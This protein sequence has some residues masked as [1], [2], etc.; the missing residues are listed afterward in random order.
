VVIHPCLFLNEEKIEIAKQ[1]IARYEWARSIYHEL[2][3]DA[4]KLPQAEL[5]VFETAW[6]QEAKKKRWQEIYPEIAHH[7]YF[8][9]RTLPEIAWRSALVYR[10]G[11]R[12]I[13]AK[14][15][16]RVLLHFTTYSFEPVHPDVGMNW[17]SWG[18]RLLWTY[19]ALY[20]YC[21]PEERKKLDDFFARLVNGVA[22]CDDLWIRENPGGQ[23]NNHYAWHKMMMAAYGIFYGDDVWVKRAIESENGIRS[24]IEKGLLDDGIWFESSLNYHFAALWPLYMTAEMFRSAGNPFDLYTHRFANGRKLED[25][26]R[27]IIEIAFPDLTLPTIGDAY[28]RT[29]QI[30]DN[31]AYEYAWLAYRKPIYA[32]LL[33]QKKNKVDAVRLFQNAPADDDVNQRPRTLRNKPRAPVAKSRVFPEHGYAMLRSVEGRDYWGSNSWAAFMSFDLDSIHSHRDKLNLILFGQGRVWARDV[34]ALS[35]AEHAFSSKVQKEL[36]RSTI[37]HNTLMVDRLDHRAIGQKLPLIEFESTKDTKTAT[38]ADLSGCVYPGVRL[39][40]TIAVTKQYVLDVFQAD[41]IASLQFIGSIQVTKQYVLDVFQADSESEHT[42]D[43]LFHAG[44]DDGI[45]QIHVDSKNPILWSAEKEEW[46]SPPWNW[47]RNA[48]NT[49]TD[50]T[51]HAEWRQNNT[52]FK[53]SMLGVPATKIT[54]C[55]FPRNDR[56]E[57]PSIPMLLVTRRGRSALFVAVY[58]AGNEEIPD[59]HITISRDKSLKVTITICQKSYTH[60][61]MRLDS[62]KAD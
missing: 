26:F 59:A 6:W 33:S 24:L 27:G 3:L 17:S 62:L 5:P 43:W 50:Q 49:Y 14:R 11:G 25:A 41:F 19:D 21:T 44:S 37:C 54:I 56:F 18:I 30:A 4:D 60:E 47:L 42:F 48:R 45:T 51:W 39:M 16:K 9:P 8:V 29:M 22:K 57:P 1:N 7:T 12:D 32:W 38:A 55:D 34:E 15:A 28:G 36:N 52:R 35:S 46:R 13:Y 58:Q 23:Y 31:P 20:E 61:V 40:R 10:L 53:L 2:K